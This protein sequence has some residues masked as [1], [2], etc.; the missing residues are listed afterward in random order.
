MRTREGLNTNLAPE[1]RS[2]GLL[3]GTSW[4]PQDKSPGAVDGVERAR[5]MDSLLV[6]ADIGG[7]TSGPG[8]P[9]A[10]VSQEAGLHPVAA[11]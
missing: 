5:R 1:A 7:S 11:G 10:G 2:E 4:V 6:A 3:D 9:V 8:P